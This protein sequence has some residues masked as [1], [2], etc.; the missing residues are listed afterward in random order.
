[1][2]EIIELKQQKIFKVYGSI[3]LLRKY[4]QGD[5]EI[6][7]YLIDGKKFTG[8]LRWFDDYAI[9][10]ILSDG[11]ITIPIHNIAQFECEHFLLDGEIDDNNRV[12]RGM[13][14]STEREQEQLKKYRKNNELIHFYLKDE[15]E[16][17][18]RLQW[19]LEY[20]YAV[21]PEKSSRDC[22][23]TKR[24]ILYYKKIEVN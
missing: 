14:R 21:R 20:V 6:T 13:A 18:G 16:V 19:L 3:S 1:M 22:M 9:K 11:S 4:K 7:V 15:I 24:Q 23:I 2:E 17:R 8:K 12:F 10:V 5:K